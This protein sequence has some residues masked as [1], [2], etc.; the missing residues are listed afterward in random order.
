VYHPASSIVLEVRSEKSE[1]V[2]KRAQVEL[3]K[4]L[5]RS[6]A[7]ARMGDRR[8]ERARFRRVAVN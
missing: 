4:I 2:G 3:G 7:E 5:C 1:P 8:K 6:W